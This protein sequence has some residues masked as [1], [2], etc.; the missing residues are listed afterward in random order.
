MTLPS[1]D[2]RRS[3]ALGILCGTGAAVFWAAGFVAARHGIDI[4]FTPAD[5]MVHRF[6]WA[7]LA[8]LPLFIQGG[9][10][11]LNGIGWFRGIV[12]TILGGPGLALISYSGFLLVPLGHGA[13]I[14]PSC[15]ALFGLLLASVVLKERLPIHRL[16]G[17]F[18]MIAGLA[19]IGG[20]A[21]ATIGAHGV[22]GDFAFAMAGIFFAIFGMLLRLWRIVPTRAAIVVSVVSLAYLP[23]HGALGGFER[24]AALGL[25]ENLLQ[26]V[27][28]GVLA[29]AGGIYLFARSVVLLGAGRAA[30]FPSLVPGCALLIGYLALGEVPTVAQLVSFAIVLLG[31]RLTQKP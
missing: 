12:L 5:L 13:V 7:G 3:T 17:A 31:F 20:E 27:L 8:L 30:V 16:V 1:S 15:A 4:G 22:L 2:Q 26:A 9:V 11:D 21:I 29:G 14:Q 10:G 19:V 25:Q 24:M 18:T 28:Q 6:L 23:V